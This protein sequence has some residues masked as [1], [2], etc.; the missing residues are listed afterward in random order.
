VVSARGSGDDAIVEVVREE[1][2]GRVC[3]VATADRG[4]ATRVKALGAVV[5]GPKSV[6]RR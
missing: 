3:V 5:I 1:G 6:P 4:L 2:A